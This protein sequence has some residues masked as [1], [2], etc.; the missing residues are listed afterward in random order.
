[1]D[2]D[3]IRR[4]RENTRRQIESNDPDLIKLTI[5]TYNHNYIPYD[6]DWA[7]D[8]KGI[9]RNEHIK[10][11]HFGFNLGIVAR[12]HGGRDNFEAF[13]A[14]LAGNKSIKRLD[15]FCCEIFGGKIFN[16]LVPFFQQNS[17][18]HHLRVCGGYQQPYGVRFLSESLSIF[19]NLRG[20]DCGSSRL[21]DSDVEALIL[22]LAGHTRLAKIGLGV[23]EVGERGV[24]ALAALL[25][26]PR[27]TLAELD[28]AYCSLN[29]ERAVILAAALGDRNITLKKLNLSSNSNITSSGWSAIFT[30]LQSPQ[31]PL[32][33]LDLH[34]NS[35]DDAA[36]N[37]L[38]NALAN[39]THLKVLNL[40]EISREGWRPIISSDGWRS[41]FD[42][43]Q[44]PRCMLQELD[45]NGNNLDD[46]DVTYL[47]SSLSNNCVLSSLTLCCNGGVTAWRAFSVVLQNPNSALEKIDLGYSSIGNDI[48]VSFANSLVHNNKLKELFLDFSVEGVPIT[49]WDAL[50]NV[51]CNKS[52]INATFSSNHTLQCVVDPDITGEARLP[53][54]LVTLLQLNRE[55]APTEAARRKVLKVHFSTNFN[56]QPF[57]N[58]DLKVLPH[59]IAWMARDE[60]GGSLLYQ[61]VRNATLFVNLGG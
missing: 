9:G 4:R 44:S 31:P 59:A 19:D 56:M 52:S 29:D 26:N 54:D 32:E 49:E 6:G 57:N 51:L 14:G 34:G 36:A 37:L 8:G 25:N 16:M 39:N 33:D 11:L 17:N 15:I 42:A 13:C 23:N 1:M 12:R 48:L 30:Q 21:C 35:I 55:S 61:F 7:R 47:A 41:I 50:T 24:N 38:G 40:S 60:Y 27:S 46:E 45:L 58:M 53:P 22:S 18:L 43:L 5:N 3:D 10:E 28:L 20:F 2:E